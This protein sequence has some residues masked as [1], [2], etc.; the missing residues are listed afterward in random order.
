MTGDSSVVRSDESLSSAMSLT[1][2]TVV[3]VSI[4]DLTAMPEGREVGM[5][6]YLSVD[7]DRIVKFAEVT[8]D[9]QWIHVDRD[10]ARAESPFGGVIA[11]GFLTLALLPVMFR[12]TILIRDV[13]LAVNC[14]VNFVRFM[15]PVPAGARIRARFRYRR[16]AVVRGQCELTWF[17][18][19]ERQGSA[20]PVCVCEW[21]VRLLK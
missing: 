10:R 5:S 20:T 21:I 1:E 13:R 16:S 18:T 4:D 8:E 15:S 7:E 3:D 11:H 17:V 6:P 2:A 9:R 12:S 19:I 14:G